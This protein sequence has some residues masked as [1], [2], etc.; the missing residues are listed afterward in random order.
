MRCSCNITEDEI[1]GVVGNVAFENLIC[2]VAL[3]EFL[4]ASFIVASFLPLLDEKMCVKEGS[5][6]D[7]LDNIPELYLK[8]AQVE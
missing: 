3:V 8:G 5:E 6:F 2:C 4:L 7:D 1:V